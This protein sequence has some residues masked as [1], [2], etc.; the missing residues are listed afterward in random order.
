[1]HSCITGHGTANYTKAW[2]IH[3]LHVVCVQQAGMEDP[4]CSLQEAKGKLKTQKTN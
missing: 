1:M 2:T 4:V 3:K